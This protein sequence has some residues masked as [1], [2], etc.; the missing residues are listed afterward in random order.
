MKL[1][2]IGP[3][4]DRELGKHGLRADYVPKVYD[5][6]HLGAGL[7]DVAGGRVLILRAG[8]GSP[9]LP[10]ALDRAGVGY[11]DVPVYDTRYENPESQELRAMVERGEIDLVTFTSASTV[12]GFV[13][14]VGEGTDLSGITGA[15]IGAQTAAEAE[16]HGIRTVVAAKATMDDLVKVILGMT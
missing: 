10:Q 3:G 11:D 7:A 15:C 5:A 6:A 14:S 4:T 9:E 8:I 1:A 16:K 13:S 12:K 2:A